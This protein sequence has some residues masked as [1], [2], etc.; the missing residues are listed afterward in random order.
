MK[1]SFPG[2]HQTRTLLQE[3]VGDYRR[4][5][6]EGKKFHKVIFKKAHL[7]HNKKEMLDFINF[8]NCSFQ[9]TV[10]KNTDKPIIREE[11]WSPDF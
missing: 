2:W 8:K 9:Y 3:N 4:N 10:F 11:G 6:M 5:Q 1:L 7:S